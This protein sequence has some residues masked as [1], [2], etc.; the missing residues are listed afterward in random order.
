M[1]YK[2]R[3]S[4]PATKKFG[5]KPTAVKLHKESNKSKTPPRNYEFVVVKVSGVE[6]KDLYDNGKV[7][8]KRIRAQIEQDI[9]VHKY[10]ADV[11]LEVKSAVFLVKRIDGRYQRPELTV[12]GTRKEGKLSW[13]RV[14]ETIKLKK[15]I[16]V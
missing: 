10:F 14:P 15:A 3:T 12:V 5:G 9:S 8:W 1:R 6:K 13:V 4:R 11:E 2:S 16:H 7:L